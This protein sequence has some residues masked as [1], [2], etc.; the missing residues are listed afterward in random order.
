MVV[1]QL[2]ATSRVV[3]LIV[4]KHAYGQLFFQLSLC[5]SLFALTYA[6]VLNRA[7]EPLVLPNKEFEELTATQLR[8]YAVK[9]KKDMFTTER[10]LKQGQTICYR[11][12]DFRVMLQQ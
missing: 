10:D 6:L 12:S 7:A 8:P 3:L 11:L 5:S 1:F 2:S 9:S 4:C